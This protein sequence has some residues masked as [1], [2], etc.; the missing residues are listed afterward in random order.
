M[1]TQAR[2][3]PATPSNKATQP[4]HPTSMSIN[5]PQDYGIFSARACKSAHSSSNYTMANV[6]QINRKL[7]AQ[8]FSIFKPAI[9]AHSDTEMDLKS[10]KLFHEVLAFNHRAE[11]DRHKYSLPYAVITQTT[12]E[13]VLQKTI[14]Q[15][16]ERIASAMQRFVF[17]VDKKKMFEITGEKNAATVSP[18]DRIV[19]EGQKITV[20]LAPTFKKLLVRFQQFYL[21]DARTVRSLNHKASIHMYWLIISYSWKGNSF[22]ISL[23]DL[24]DLLGCSGAYQDRWDHFKDRILNPIYQEFLGTWCEF[25]YQPQKK[26]RKI[27]SLIFNFKS[28][29]QVI[30]SIINESPFRFEHTLQQLR[31]DYKSIIDIRGRVQRGEYT[32]QDVERVIAYV[33]ANKTIRSK[34]GYIIKALKERIFE[35]LAV[36]TELAITPSPSSPPPTNGYWG[37]VQHRWGFSEEQMKELATLYNEHTVK[38]ADYGLS[39]YYPPDNAPTPDEAF[40]AFVKRADKKPI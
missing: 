17:R 40:A 37:K 13:R 23:E 25:S 29:A 4:T 6:P 32:E 21:G 3:L 19:Y 16:V 31:L 30:R 8:E 33:Q 20:V 35:R 34:G 10:L 26:G 39:I 15:E 11:A 5:S 36:Q 24:K 2:C 12:N 18:F 9:I 28:D 38:R 22:E 27:T 14:A 1:Q 7:I